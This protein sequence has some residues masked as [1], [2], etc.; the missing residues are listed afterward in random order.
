MAS[1]QYRCKS[2]GKTHAALRLPE[3]TMYLR[4][5]VTRDWAWYEPSSFRV[6]LAGARSAGRDGHASTSG[7]RRQR[8][9]A[10]RRP[11]AARAGRAAVRKTPRKARKRK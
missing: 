5:L 8:V 3:G 9:A 1:W 11:A 4:C 2:C 7:A 10:R 6:V